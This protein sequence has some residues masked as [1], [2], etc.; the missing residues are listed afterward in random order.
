MDEQKKKRRGEKEAL[1][2]RER[3]GEERREG[4]VAGRDFDEA[5][6]AARERCL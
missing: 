3:E 1:T 6:S 2:L 5:S 4:L